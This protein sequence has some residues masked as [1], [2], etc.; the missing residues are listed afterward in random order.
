MSDGRATVLIV[1]ARGESALYRY[2]CR[3]VEGDTHVAVIVDRRHGER[4]CSQARLFNDRRRADRRVRE[5][6]R[7]LARLGRLRAVAPAATPERD[8]DDDARLRTAAAGHHN[9]WS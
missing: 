8:S 1:V 5:N 2:L 9:A 4:R 6:D 3:A 7:E